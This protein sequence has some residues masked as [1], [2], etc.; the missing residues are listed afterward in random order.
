ML[1]SDFQVV[2][3][4]RVLSRVQCGR[5]VG[6]DQGS[7]YGATRGVFLRRQQGRGRD[8]GRG[9]GTFK[10]YKFTVNPVFFVHCVFFFLGLFCLP[11]ASAEV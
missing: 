4:A 6:G 9:S 11:R 8:R 1:V 2:S 3:T 5:C 10:T 7:R